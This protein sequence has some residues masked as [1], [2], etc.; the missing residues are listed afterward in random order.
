MRSINL[1]LKN[2]DANILYLLLKTKF[3]AQKS[4]RNTFLRQN[5]KEFS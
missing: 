2:Y 5:K 3:L 1:A 4:P